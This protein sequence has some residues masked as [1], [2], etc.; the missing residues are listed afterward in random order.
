MMLRSVCDVPLTNQ[1][2]Y[3]MP[4]TPVHDDDPSLSKDEKD[5]P[6]ASI[7]QYA[8]PVT[9]GCDD[10]SA[11]KLPISESA[12]TV[13]RGLLQRP[14]LG[15]QQIESL[16]KS[17]YGKTVGKQCADTEQDSTLDMIHQL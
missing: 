16:M 4:A 12:L 8:M 5:A 10:E 11:A 7:G 14:L 13:H 17:Q 15:P 3:A 1:S 6:P 9:P 2:W